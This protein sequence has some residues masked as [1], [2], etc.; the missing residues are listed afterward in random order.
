MTLLE[1]RKTRGSLAYHSGVAAED[2]VASLYMRSG[3]PVIE[4]RWRGQ[5]GEIDLIAQD[6][7]VI[8]FIE[9]KKSR[10]HDEAALHLS[11]RQMARIYGA[12]SEFLGT[13]PKGQLTDVRFDVALVD[14]TGQIKVIENA[15]DHF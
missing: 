10:S 9:V 1:Q 8:V 3:Q 7:D 15:F 4:R 11:Q 2:S 13:Q 5:S 6:G 12:G 14:D